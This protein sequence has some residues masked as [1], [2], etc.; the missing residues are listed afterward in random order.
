M[1]ARNGL[2]LSV[3]AVLAMFAGGCGYQVGNLYRDD[4][5]TVAVDMFTRGRMVYRRELETRATEAIVKRINLT[6]YRIAPKNQADTILT[7]S[8]D[9]VP[10]RV[11][12]YDPDSGRPRFKELLL[13]VSFQWKDQRTGKVLVEHEN[14]IVSG[15]YVTHEP[16]NE[17]FFQG[18]EDVVNRL[19]ERIVAYMERDWSQ[20]PPQPDAADGE[21]QAGSRP[22]GS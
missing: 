10:Q 22:I 12:Q 16:L 3:S 14:V 6:P 9:V 18:S 15:T 8:I 19:A 5:D 2:L 17:D 11:P 21:K 4:V 13:K 7:G 1:N 20:P